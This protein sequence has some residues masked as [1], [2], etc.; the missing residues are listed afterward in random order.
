MKQGYCVCPL[1]CGVHCNF[2]G[3]G[4]CNERGWASSPHP[5]QPGLILPAWWNVRQK[6]AVATLCTL[7]FTLDAL[8]RLAC[9][10]KGG[11][12]L[13]Q[14]S[15]HV[16]FSTSR[17]LCLSQTNREKDQ[18]KREDIEFCQSWLNKTSTNGS[19]IF[20]AIK[21]SAKIGSFY[22]TRICPGF[23]IA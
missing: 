19:H 21:S 12:S 15:V 17:R 9:G 14:N 2:T 22:E 13:F 23:C 18:R 5:Y 6:A 4:K 3:D 7:W 11:W 8:A 20:G 16:P 10:G 1:S